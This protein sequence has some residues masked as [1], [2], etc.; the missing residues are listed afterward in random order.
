MKGFT[1]RAILA[2]CVGAAN[3]YFCRLW[4]QPKCTKYTIDI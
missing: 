1:K 2:A 3:A 4:F